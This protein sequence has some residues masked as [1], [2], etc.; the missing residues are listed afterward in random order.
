MKVSQLKARLAELDQ[1]TIAQADGAL[2]PAHFH[3]TE[4][5]LNIK[6]FMDCGGQMR[7]EKTAGLQ[8][9]VANDTDHRLEPHKLLKIIAKTEKLFGDDDLD[10]EVEYQTD[11]IGKY[12]L[13]FEAGRFVLQS[14]HTECLAQEQCNI[15]NPKF[16]LQ[17]SGCTPGGGCC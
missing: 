17:L 7:S 16:E 13:A 12:G 14:K 5:G 4:M 6:Q 11:T 9:W 3:I 1:L 10:I 15:P 8:I 2:I